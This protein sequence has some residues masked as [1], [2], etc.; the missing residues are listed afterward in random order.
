MSTHELE[1]YTT[2]PEIPLSDISNNIFKYKI[3]KDD[4]LWKQYVEK[5]APFDERL[6][7]EW[8]KIVDVIIVS[9]SISGSLPFYDISGGLSL[10]GIG[11]AIHLRPDLLCHRYH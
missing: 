8:N 3:E 1:S 9:V 10:N 5:A 2:S 11:C 4:P 7:D 6:L